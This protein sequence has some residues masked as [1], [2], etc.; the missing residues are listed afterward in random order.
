MPSNTAQCTTNK[1]D[2]HVKRSTSTS[3]IYIVCFI[4]SCIIYI[5]HKTTR[6]VKTCP[7]CM[8][9]ELEDRKSYE[10]RVIDFGK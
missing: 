3:T 7:P 6:V 9:D 5:S 10:I 2:T 8:F 1:I 4:R